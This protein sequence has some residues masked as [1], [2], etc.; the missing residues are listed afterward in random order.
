VP[1][2]FARH[3]RAVWR[4]QYG[5]LLYREEAEGLT[6]EGVLAAAKPSSR[7]AKIRAKRQ[8]WRGSFLTA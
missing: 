6:T 3:I 5:N 4:E 2:N 1:K 8:K 7:A